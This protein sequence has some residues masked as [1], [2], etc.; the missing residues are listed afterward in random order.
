MSV[1]RCSMLYDRCTN[2]PTKIESIKSEKGEWTMKNEK[3]K[4]KIK[5]IDYKYV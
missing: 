2:V 5:F 4:M 3:W 1:I